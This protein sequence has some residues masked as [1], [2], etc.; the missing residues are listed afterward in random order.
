MK[1]KIIFFTGSRADYGLMRD[2]IINIQRKTKI[3]NNVI[4]SGSHLSKKFGYTINEIIL[5]KIKNIKSIQILQ[6]KSDDINIANNFSLAV[7]KISNLLNV[8][9]PSLLVLLGDRYEVLAAAVSAM[10]C[11]IPIAHIHGGEVTE[12]AFDD[13]IRHSISKMSHIHFTTHIKHKKRLMQL[14]ENPKKIFNFGGP[15][16]SA[17]ESMKLL[18]KIEIEKNI[19]IKLDKE[20]FLITFHPVTLEKDRALKDFG[21]LLKS[22]K[23]FTKVTQIFSFPNSDNEN[24]ILIKVLKKYIRENKNAFYVKSLGQKK[25]LS[26]LKYSSGII[27]NSSS[28]ILE[29]PSFKIPTLNIGDRQK[30]RIQAKSILNCMPIKNEISKMI[31]KMFSKSFK[32]KI[33]KTKNPFFKKNTIIN[34]SKELL[35]FKS[36]NLKKQFFNIK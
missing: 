5:D 9:K 21:E 17:I 25:Y 1:K 6:K 8:S 18:K 24:D 34:I 2:I 27:G 33:S 10:I 7:K 13:A 23:G 3:K 20:Y 30:G 29:A 26:L 32:K 4:V 16:A 36:E 15:G 12:G 11:R 22:L 28:G 19:R 31:I 14:G 35:K